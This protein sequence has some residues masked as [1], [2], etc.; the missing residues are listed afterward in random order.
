[1]LRWISLPPPRPDAGVTEEHLRIVFH[2]VARPAC[3]SPDLSTPSG[4]GYF[5]L[6]EFLR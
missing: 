3:S 1:M 4:D 5:F 2:G 6:G